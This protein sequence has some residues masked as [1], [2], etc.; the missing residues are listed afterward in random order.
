MVMELIYVQSND[1]Q[2]ETKR[3]IVNQKLLR[4]LRALRGE[5]K[6]TTKHTKGRKDI[7]HREHGERIYGYG[8]NL[9]AN[10]RRTG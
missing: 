5:K 10:K 1:A 2:D 6:L 8:V 3:N 7:S 9:Y 4:D